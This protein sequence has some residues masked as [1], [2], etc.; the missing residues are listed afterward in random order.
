MNAT[1]KAIS[2][3][4]PFDPSSDKPLHV[5]DCDNCLYLGS[6]ARDTRHT[7][8]LYY[9]DQMGVPTYVARW[10]NDDKYDSGIGFITRHSVL[11]LAFARH[12]SMQY[13]KG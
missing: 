7:W 1:L 2:G 3:Y 8:D 6:H 10:G 9:C 5:H 11:A 4:R 12:M 13:G